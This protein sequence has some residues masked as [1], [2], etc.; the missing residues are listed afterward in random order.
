M[1]MCPPTGSTSTTVPAP[2]DNWSA[3]RST[4]S[5]LTPDEVVFEMDQLNYDFHLLSETS[6]AAK[7]LS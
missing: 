4:P 5:E 6:P 7:M 1:G 3:Q 2:N